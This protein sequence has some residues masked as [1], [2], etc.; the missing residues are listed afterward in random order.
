[1]KNLIPRLVTIILLICLQISVYCQDIMTKKVQ[2]ESGQ[3]SPVWI[4][5]VI[6]V[7]PLAFLVFVIARGNKTR[8]EVRNDENKQERV[9]EN[10]MP[11]KK[12]P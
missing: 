7:I 12:L 2:K 3:T 9:A 6:A 4:W 11:D 1:M 8:K 10:T 5:I